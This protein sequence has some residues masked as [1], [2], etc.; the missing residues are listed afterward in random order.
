MNTL[1]EFQKQFVETLLSEH[2]NTRFLQQLKSNGEKQK[3]FSVYRNNT[4]HSLC[5]ALGDTYPIVKR[6]VG[7]V[8]FKQIA[9]D[10]V[11]NNP[12]TAPSLSYYG[13][14][15]IHFI[16]TSTLNNALPYLSDVALLEWYYQYAFHSSDQPTLNIKA[17]Q[18]IST[19]QL[20]QIRL[21]PLTSVNLL[22]SS[23]PIDIIW[24]ENLKA[25][26][27]VIDLDQF[28]PTHLLIYR[29][30]LE[31]AII[32]LQ[33]NTFKLLQGLCQGNTL[34]AAWK[35]TTIPIEELSNQLAYLLNLHIFSSYT[36]D[37][38]EY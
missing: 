9:L 23:F 27:E 5:E 16:K 6:L 3:C 29:P 1:R 33:S 22:S 28:T 13:E 10:F 35:N 8:S 11:R 19:K 18:S 14:N 4:L 12:P 30:L 31:V 2:I 7:D 37:I 32:S 20:H 36:I 17:L 34:E 26:I 24:E 21:I 25:N 38:N 15:F